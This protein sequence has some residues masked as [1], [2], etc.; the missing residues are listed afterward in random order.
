MN[1]TKLVLILSSLLLPAFSASGAAPIKVGVI[2]LDNYQS[3]AFASLFQ[4]AKP[5]EP[6]AGFEVVA[7]FPGGSPDIPESA[8]SLPRW[9]ES[10]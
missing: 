6:L 5:G 8:K 7:A 3:V 10:F 9:I 4:S 1:N 2:G